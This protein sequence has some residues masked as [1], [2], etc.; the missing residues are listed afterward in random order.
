MTAPNSVREALIAEAIGDLG[1][2][3]E[4]TQAL[5]SAMEESRRSLLTAQKQLA[6]HLAAFDTQLLA[7]TDKAKVHLAK[8]IAARTEEAAQR[9][10]QVQCQAMAEA[11]R[12]AFGAE[13]GARLQRLHALIQPLLDRRAQRFES[14]LT[15]TAAAIGAS[16]L[17]GVMAWLLMGC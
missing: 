2:L 15:H 9:S 7:M 11:A 3:I 10:A 17:T 14:F 5:H 16:A 4:Q 12:V 13:V 1:R 8:H 6:S